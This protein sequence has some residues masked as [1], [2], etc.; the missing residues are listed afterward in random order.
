MVPCWMMALRWARVTMPAWKKPAY[1]QNIS[2]L[3]ALSAPSR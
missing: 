2:R 3:K 1:S